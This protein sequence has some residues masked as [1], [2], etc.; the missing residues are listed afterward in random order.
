MNRHTRGDTITFKATNFLTSAG[1]A[2]TPTT[3]VVYLDYPGSSR[4]RSQATVSLT[5]SSGTWTGTWDSEVAFPGTVYAS[6]KAEGTD[7]FALDTSFQ[8]GANIA[9]PDPA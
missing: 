6:L 9:N 4:A 3:V 2:A 8:L 1:A 5:N 7:D